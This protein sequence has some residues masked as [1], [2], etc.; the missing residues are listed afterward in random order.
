ML[1]A[2]VALAAAQLGSYAGPGD[3]AGA[4]DGGLEVNIPGVPG[5]D[6]PILAQVPDT[7]L[8]ISQRCTT[9]VQRLEKVQHKRYKRYRDGSWRNRGQH[10]FGLKT[11]QQWR[12]STLKLC[13]VDADVLITAATTTKTYI[14]TN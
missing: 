13:R 8:P 9:E 6:Y 10:K 2:V 12:G 11:A 7:G 4:G 5:E 14:V 1:G 3:E